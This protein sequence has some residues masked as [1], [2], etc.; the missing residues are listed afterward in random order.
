[1]PIVG[2]GGGAGAAATDYSETMDAV[3]AVPEGV[4]QVLDVLESVGLVLDSTD[5]VVRASPG[6]H[7]FGLV[8]D[9]A[10]AHDELAEIAGLARASGSAAREIQLSRG[11]FGSASLYLM[12]RAARLGSQ[13]ILL[14]AEDRT[15]AHRLDDVRR[16]FIANISHELKTPI[17]AVTLLAEALHEAA[18]EP[19][20]VRRF[21]DRLTTEAERLAGITQ[22]IIELSRLQALDA[23]DS[24]ELVD[25]DEV[26]ATAIDQN[27]VGAETNGIAVVAG[28][29]S[30]ARVHGN[31]PMLVAVLHNLIAN[32]VIYSPAGTRVAI[33][34]SCA[35][36][37]VEITVADQGVGIPEQELERVF[38]RFFRGDPARSRNTGGSGLGLSIVKHAVHSHGGEVHVRSRLGQGS[39]FTIRLPEAS[40]GRGS[41]A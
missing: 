10:L 3:E 30:H 25:I 40:Q 9:G 22:E 7:S 12:V 32:A 38:E 28:E 8:R 27:R 26:V 31:E 14:L 2:P 33:E 20:E 6:A 5:A 18:D 24:P 29:P 39:T 35:G 37:I 41:A 34:V 17:G 19:E 11:P 23:L 1:M 21:A 15:T 36:G 4:E 13:H 16:D